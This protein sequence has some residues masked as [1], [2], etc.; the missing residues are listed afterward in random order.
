MNASNQ[1][2]VAKMILANPDEIKI[3]FY[4]NMYFVNETDRKNYDK[5]VNSSDFI[6]EAY[7]QGDY[8]SL[9]KV[10]FGLPSPEE[11]LMDLIENPDKID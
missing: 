10:V 5:Y 2:F 11:I 8:L 6:L 7:S 9:G 3:P 1:T 4:R